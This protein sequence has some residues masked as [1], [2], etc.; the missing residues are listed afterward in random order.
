M[1]V[2]AHVTV[3]APLEVDIEDVVPPRPLRDF[4]AADSSNCNSSHRTVSN[5]ACVWVLYGGD[6]TV[7]VM[8]SMGLFCIGEI[9]AVASLNMHCYKNDCIFV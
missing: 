3:A 8:F 4:S 7:Y 2:G 1:G 6:K 9:C 5:A